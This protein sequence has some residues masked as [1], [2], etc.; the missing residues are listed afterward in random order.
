MCDLRADQIINDLCN[1]TQH[2]SGINNRRKI[3]ELS[4]AWHC[5][6]VGTCLTLADLRGLARKLNVRTLPGYSIDYQLHGLF[7]K[8]AE[9]DKKP[10]K[11]L[12]KLL[13][14]RH[15]ASIR[16]VRVMDT[17]Y[18]LRGFWARALDDGDIPGPYWA[19]LSHPAT[20]EE[21]GEKMFA[22]VHMLSHL[23]GASNRAN[24]SKLNEVQEQIVDLDQKFSRQQRQHIKSLENRDQII[25]KLRMEIRDFQVTSTSTP[26]PYKYLNPLPS[27]HSFSSLHKNISELSEKLHLSNNIIKKEEEKIKN[28]E[29][30]VLELREENA[31]LEGIVLQAHKDGG[32]REPID[33]NGQCLLYVGGQRRTVHRL[34]DLVQDWNG[35]FIHH[36]GGLESSINELA[37]A[38]NRADTIIFPVDCVSHSAANKVKRLCQQSMKPFI[39]LRTSGVGSFVSGLR[40]GLKSSSPLI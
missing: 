12:N 6:V 34:R 22:D 20:S 10:G 5:T 33:L 18:E 16:K 19:I 39:T 23:V 29:A 31:D 1:K 21:L 36:D 38:V 7:V 25:S 3:W 11:M 32:Q 40:D 28:L 30:F 15:A 26:K 2:I 14:K 9:Q 27:P 37:S 35:K 13:D 4:S 24:I 17:E 8:E